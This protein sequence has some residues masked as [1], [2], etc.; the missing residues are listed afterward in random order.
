MS[1]V[2]ALQV[3]FYIYIYSA[4][5]AQLFVLGYRFTS[6]DADLLL[7]FYYYL[8]VKLFYQFCD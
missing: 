1:T 3:T 5:G 2:M 6:S 7:F 4:E 8:P